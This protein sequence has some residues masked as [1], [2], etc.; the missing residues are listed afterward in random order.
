MSKPGNM[1]FNGGEK[2]R[3]K[4]FAILL[5]VALLFYLQSFLPKAPT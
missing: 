1:Y 4:E 5:L 3:V 2:D